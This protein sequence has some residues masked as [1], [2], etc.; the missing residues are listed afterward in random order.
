MSEYKN[1]NSGVLF[2]NDRKEKE[3]HPDYKGSINVNGVDFWL[4]AWIKSGAKGKFMSL[5]VQP[6]EAQAPKPTPKPTGSGF[7]DVDSDLPF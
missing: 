7:D 1:E 5:S 2:K 6:K 4:S 3:N